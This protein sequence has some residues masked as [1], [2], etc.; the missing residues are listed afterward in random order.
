MA[1]MRGGGSRAAGEHD[2][3][4]GDDAEPAWRRLPVARHW[5]VTGLLM[6]A[7]PSLL[8]NEVGAQVRARERHRPGEPE[9]QLMVY[10]A[11]V[12]ANSPAG[13][14]PP[15]GTRALAGIEASYVPALSRA[16]RTVQADKPEATNLA[17]AFPR[18]RA[19]ALVKGTALDF[20]WVPGVPVAGVRAN[21]VGLAASRTI[22]TW[23]G[24]HFTPRLSGLTGRVEGSFTC[25]ARTA[26]D[27]GMALEVYYANVCHGNDSRDRFEPTRGAAELVASRL[28]RGRIDSYIMAGVRHERARFDIGVIRADGSRDPDHP[29]LET[30]VT[31]GYGAAGA[32]WSFGA[33]AIASGEVFYTPGTLVTARVF[34]GVRLW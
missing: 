22:A 9:G 30:R 5:R 31:K 21:V 19:I 12:L 2:S 15:A 3:A 7:L 34:A 27:E 6:A 18:A 20:S 33:R 32:T 10:Y 25:N 11:S 8:P 16:R 24:I 4:G 13:L 17:R 23:Q 14:L 1:R 26:R 28:V 29:I